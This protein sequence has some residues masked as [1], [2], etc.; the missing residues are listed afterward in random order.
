MAIGFAIIFI[1]FMML[2]NEGSSA[3]KSPGLIVMLVGLGWFAISSIYLLA[4]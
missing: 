1:G 4:S 2:L 3:I